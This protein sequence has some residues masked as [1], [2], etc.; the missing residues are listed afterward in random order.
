MKMKAWYFLCIFFF[1]YSLSILINESY[2]VTYRIENR[3]EEYE[4]LACLD[5]KKV[6]YFSKNRK[7]I[8][9]NQ[10]N[11]DV[12][13]YFD[14]WKNVK[15]M[16]KYEFKEF[17][18]SILVPIKQRE[19]LVFR[20]MFCFPAENESK[21]IK[22]DKFI[23]LLNAYLA[24]IAY[25]KDTFDLVKMKKNRFG[26][27]DESENFDQL[28][29]LHKA[30]PYSNCT[31]G[32]SRF[33]CL[34]KCFKG[35]NR[36]SKYLY[37]TNETDGIIKLNFDNNNTTLKDDED[38]CFRECKNDECKF[39]YF[40]KSQTIKT[41]INFFKA[42]PTMSPVDYWI[43]L[44]GLGF[45][46]AGLSS[47]QILL[48]FIKILN[49][50]VFFNQILTKFIKIIR[51][52]I[53]K[54]KLKRQ[55]LNLTKAIIVVIMISFII[56]SYFGLI[57]KYK[58]NLDVP[59]KKE[60]K[61]ILL[62][63]EPI[64]LLI[65]VY[66]EYIFTNGLWIFKGDTYLNKSLLELEKETEMSFKN[67]L[68]E[69][70]IEF[71]NE[72]IEVKW[73]LKSKVFFYEFYF[74]SRCFMVDVFPSEPKYQ[75]ALS[76][77]KL[78]IKFH[79][80]KYDIFLLA[81]GQ[82][83]HSNSY[84]FNRDYDFIK[85]ITKSTKECENY[86][87]LN[88]NSSCVSKEECIDRCYNQEFI[89]NYG[90]I[91][92][93]SITDK[94]HFTKEQWEKLFVDQK[95]DEN[96][97]TKCKEQ[98]TKKDCFEVKFE[99]N[100]QTTTTSDKFATFDLY[101]DILKEI[102]IRPT[103]YDL[104][105]DMINIQS[106]FFGLNTFK[107]LFMIYILIES[108]LK[109]YLLITIY[110]I[111]ILGSTYQTYY[112]LNEIVNE[113][114]DQS[115]HYKLLETLRMPEIIFCLDFDESLIDV[116]HKLT[117]NY[118]DK[119]TEDI[120]VETVFYM[121]HYLDN[122]TNEWIMLEST[123][124]DDQ[125]RIEEFFLLN[126]KCFKIILEMEYQRDQLHFSLDSNFVSNVLRIF[127]KA[128]FKKRIFYFM[129]KP[130]NKIQFSKLL[131]LDF[132]QGYLN[133][134]YSKKTLLISQELFEL[135]YNDKFNFIKNPIS[136]FYGENDAP[137]YL[138]NLLNNFKNFNHLR[139]LKLPLKKND[140]KLEVDDDLFEQYY[141]QVQNVTDNYLSADTNYSRLLAT[142]YYSKESVFRVGPDFIFNLIFYKKV[143]TITNRGNYSR[144]IMNLLDVL[145]IWFGL[146]VLDLH[147]YVHKIKFI[148]FF[149]VK[150]MLKIERL[151][152]KLR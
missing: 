36:L 119:I 61:L 48:K 7:N 100:I 104:L 86:D 58:L 115:Q 26:K 93:H 72:K 65:C 106:Y 145:S 126:E 144:L 134:L 74:F 57:V 137:H 85:K 111:C 149:I 105:I 138:N 83:F 51:Y 95:F 78:V 120:R 80:N 124:K 92:A 34:N 22:I 141:L 40:T 28:I 8:G 75:S 107:L 148:L 62:E 35:K 20:D 132:K 91:S 19:C 128:N 70:Y 129:T 5:F 121:I 76:I 82:S 38:E 112:I 103:V 97:R 21:L 29:V 108:K 151:I 152:L 90:N 32:Y 131:E 127:F 113:E 55:L 23:Y 130:K 54:D 14:K 77:S 102:E 44:T 69:I 146:G 27:L 94:D 150:L 17:N 13:N 42:H 139:T 30:Y 73:S 16:G 45:F 9:L 87:R 143:I 53:Q 59:S 31:E 60:V 81:D 24:L 12:Y 99:R 15:W 64:S 33:H 25:K 123:F 125:F 118:L 50:S 18:E 140:F 98:I 41:T 114:L 79:H 122:R 63:P 136:V 147:P 10:L 66:L 101:Y 6:I 37:R 46:F 11:R 39:T 2:D 96:I 84:R 117:G 88:S 47:Y 43:Q 52:K 135:I 1:F 142:N 4:Y 71:Q 56:C 109:F 116:N 67:S 3:T 110:I 49:S 133:P 89:K 68:N